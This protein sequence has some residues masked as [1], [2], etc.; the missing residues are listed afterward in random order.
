MA[1]ISTVGGCGPEFQQ[2]RMEVAHLDMLVAMQPPLVAWFSWRVLVAGR[3]EGS[4]R[5][6]EIEGGSQPHW[7]AIA[8]AI[9]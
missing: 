7:F 3:L 5:P 9:P 2:I 8:S 6:V 4:R 1:L